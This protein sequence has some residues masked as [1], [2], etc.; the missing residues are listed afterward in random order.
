M[1]TTTLE[2]TA[3]P[4]RNISDHLTAGENGPP[5]QSPTGPAIFHI[6]SSQP[7]RLTARRVFDDDGL[8]PIA[9]GEEVNDP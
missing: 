3:E 2:P 1:P 4:D 9:T 5:Q 6:M 8:S 7:G